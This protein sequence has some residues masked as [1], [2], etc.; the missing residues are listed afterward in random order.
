MK[1]EAKF[2][3]YFLENLVKWSVVKCF[4]KGF[5]CFYDTF[6]EKGV[7]SVNKKKEISMKKSLL[8]LQ[9]IEELDSELYDTPQKLKELVEEV[10]QL[11][12]SEYSNSGKKESHLKISQQKI[13]LS[14]FS[15]TSS[16]K[17]INSEIKDSN[18]EN[19]KISEI[20]IQ[21]EVSEE[22]KK[23][24][25]KRKS[26]SRPLQK[27][28]EIIKNL[29]FFL[30]QPD[31][32]TKNSPRKLL[33]DI[34]PSKKYTLVLDLDE[35]LVHFQEQ[36]DGKNQFLIRP[37]AQY[38]LKEMSK[39][40]EVVIFTAAL[41]DYADFILDRL[42]VNNSWISHRLYRRHTYFSGNVYQKDLSR[43][44]R[45]LSKTLIVDNNAE[46]FQLQPDNGIYIKSWYDD[47]EDKALFQLAPLLIRIH[48]LFNYVLEI[49]KKGYE[50]VRVA[51]KKLGE[52]MMRKLQSDSY[53]EGKLFQLSLEP[54]N[55]GLGALVGNG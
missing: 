43:L 20:V 27:Q 38:F 51:M 53:D 30:F 36:P 10:K 39:W 1:N 25:K 4:E 37:Y 7:I 42:D 19:K 45:S 17:K 32:N 55:G 44:G 35:T 14:K 24:K 16:S 21:K 2:Q 41:K 26:S 15:K 8:K 52:K 28:N 54:Q 33:P 12:Q 5:E 50:D 48:F 13:S 31:S 49:V 9:E 47:P 3:K 6:K 34:S 29:P 18:N 11:K 40:Y 22:P 46:N 23:L